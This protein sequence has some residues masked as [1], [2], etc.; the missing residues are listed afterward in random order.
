MEPTS[1]FLLAIAV[2]FVIGICGELIFERTGIPDVVW[3]IVVGILIGPI[4]GI[5]DRAEL[6]RI[7]P[8]FGALTLVV[9]L[10][11]G[12]SK[13]N[14]QELRS[15]AGRSTALAVTSFLIA[16]AVLSVA[17]MVAAWMGLLPD[18]WTWLHGVILGCILGGSSSVVIMPALQKAGLSPKIANLLNLESA[19]TDVFCVVGTVA[20]I[21]IAV[22]GQADVGEAAV[23]LAKSF[24][25]GIVVGIVAGFMSLFVLRRLRRSSY[26][27][28]LILGGLLFLYVL[29]DEFGG[30]AALGILAVAVVVGNAP[31]LSKAVGLAHSAQL[32]RSVTT[33]HD[34]ITFII[35]SF[36]FTFIG[37]MLGPPAELSAA[38]GWG[39]IFFGVLLGVILLFARL[40]AAGLATVGTGMTL[41]AKG[42]VG[43]SLP[44]GMAA[45]VLAMMPAQKGVVGTED[46]PVMVFA[47]VFMTILIFAVGFPILKKQ[48]LRVDPS[49]FA[50]P[51][52]SPLPGQPAPFGSHADSFDSLAPDSL[53]PDSLAPDSIAPPGSLVAV[54]LAAPPVPA[55]SPP[56]RIDIG[57]AAG[58]DETYLDPDSAP[59]PPRRPSE[60]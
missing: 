17:S 57:G 33:T 58:A 10:F 8:Y 7:A 25:I 38:H 41:Q 45:G 37:T 12:G 47:T 1:V 56:A 40:P 24:G 19:L 51:T 59:R 42:L 35:K 49:A 48:L 31:E 11:D 22:S 46:L 16:V 2:I 39:L 20:C 27:Y 54:D 43:V 53:A 9:V 21:Q 3:L 50:A 26:A 52:P 30:S 29:I 36:F 15:A 23:T 55:E 32:G 28:P 60:P 14:L 5:V 6:V 4:G 34:S 44:R 13:L 18:S